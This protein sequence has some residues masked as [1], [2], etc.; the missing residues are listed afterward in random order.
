MRQFRTMTGAMAAALVLALTACDSATD[1]AGIITDSEL[2]QDLAAASGEAVAND[3]ADLI[4]SEQFAGLPNASVGFDLFA[5]PP[6]VM[7]TRT[8]TCYDNNVAQ[9]AC[10]AAT[11]DSVVLTMTKNGSFER[12][13]TGPRGTETFSAAVH[14]SRSLTISGLSGTE[15]TR[16]HNGTG[17]G[18]DTTDFEGTFEDV[19]ITRHVAE[20]SS[21]SIRQ[22]VFNVP[23]DPNSPY[24]VSGSIVR[25]VSGE[26]EVTAVGPNGERN[27][28]RSYTRRV[29]VTFDGDA[30]AVITIN[31]RSCTLNLGT[32]RITNCS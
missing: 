7:V 10:D 1:P 18:N 4:G 11:T 25:N 6:G 22:V 21:D 28:T 19:T 17:T 24:P 9:G 32:R 13:H 27:E 5:S 15:T 20:A 14:Q 29:V 30:T 16:I 31:S 26:V 12:S 2:D 3:V 8:R 23:R